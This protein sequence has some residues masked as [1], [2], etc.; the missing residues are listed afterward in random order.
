MDASDDGRYDLLLKAHEAQT[1]HLA[2]ERLRVAEQLDD[3]RAQLQ[4]AQ[5]E[6][7]FERRKCHS[8]EEERNS[9]RVHYQEVRAARQSLQECYDSLLQTRWHTRLQRLLR[10]G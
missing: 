7:D 9:L 4:R 2:A 8:L 6:L 3:L 1:R 5:S 10:R